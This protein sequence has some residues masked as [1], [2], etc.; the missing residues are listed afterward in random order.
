MNDMDCPICIE[1]FNKSTH[2]KIECVFCHYNVCKECVKRYLLEPKLEPSCMNCKVAWNAE[3]IR[4]IM[5]KTFLNNEYKKHREDLLLSLE[6]SLLP[7]TQEYANFQTEMNKEWQEMVE[8]KTLIR[9]LKDD[10]NIKY[11]RYFRKYNRGYSPENGEKK[12][13][14]MKCPSMECRGFLSTQYKCGQCSTAY[15]KECHQRKDNDGHE[16]REEDV[17]T[18]EMLRDNTKRCPKCSIPI[19]KLE[20]CN[21]MWCTSCHTAFSWDTG[22]IINGVVHN[23]HY[24]EWQQRL[25]QDQDEVQG[26]GEAGNGGRCHNDT[27]MLHIRHFRFLTFAQQSRVTSLLQAITHVR[28]VVIP[29]LDVQE[30]LFNDNRD[31]RIDYLNN[32]ITKKHFKWMIQ[33]RDKARQRKRVMAMIWQMFLMSYNDL[34]QNLTVHKTFDRFDAQHKELLGYIN[35]EF[36]RIG[37]L[38]SS[39]VYR[40]NDRWQ[41]V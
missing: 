3:Y 37:K 7:A 41:L 6:E 23:P 25:R 22:R 28:E 17:K 38:F 5:P 26:T 18:V 4:T 24:F 11:N 31:I 20:G 32:V 30:D 19:F 35:G 1:R 9:S 40:L 10:Y 15:C 13:F 16:C 14:V 21:Q 29:T 34:L 8:L 33:K 27:A 39:K 2:E 36:V 12:K